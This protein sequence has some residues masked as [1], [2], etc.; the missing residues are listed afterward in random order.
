MSPQQKSWSDP[1][2]KIINSFDWQ[3]HT[4]II[5]IIYMIIITVIIIIIII[6]KISLW[7]R[8]SSLCDFFILPK[9]TWAPFLASLRTDIVHKGWGF[10]PVLYPLVTKFWTKMP[11]FGVKMAPKNLLLL[12]LQNVKRSPKLFYIYVSSNFMSP[13]KLPRPFMK[14]WWKIFKMSQ[15]KIFCWRKLQKNEL[16]LLSA[17]AGNNAQRPWK[18]ATLVTLTILQ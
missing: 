15:K 4:I 5:M 13:D 2:Q 11:Y 12:C 17:A 16:S 1:G 3:L 6:N 14:Y 7:F 8:L 10:S 18:L 9:K